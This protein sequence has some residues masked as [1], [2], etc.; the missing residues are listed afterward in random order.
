MG[1]GNRWGK[2]QNHIDM[3]RSMMSQTT[4]LK[5]FWD[6]ALE[7]AARILNMVPKHKKVEKDTIRSMAMHANKLSYI[8]KSGDDEGYPKESNGIFFLL[9]IHEIKVLVAR[10]V[11]FHSPMWYYDYGFGKMDVKMPSQWTI[12][13][14]RF[15][16]EHLKVLSIQSIQTRS[17]FLATLMLDILS[18]A[19]GPKSRRDIVFRFVWR[20]NVWLTGKVFP[21]S[22]K[23]SFSL[24]HHAEES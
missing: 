23:Q 21:K 2:K 24:L 7:F 15:Y 22:A 13:M 9:L 16:M 19:V 18:D 6:Y 3:V 14:K 12:S 5:S 11:V 8:K 1:V 4:L 20:L 17:G 10:N